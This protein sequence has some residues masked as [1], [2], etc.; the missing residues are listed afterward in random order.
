[1]L[2]RAPSFSRFWLSAYRF[3]M[4]H[5]LRAFLSTSLHIVYMLV[6]FVHRCSRSHILRAMYLISSVRC[7]LLSFIS[8]LPFVLPFQLLPLISLK[9]FASSIAPSSSTHSISLLSCSNALPSPRSCHPLLFP[10]ALTIRH[11]FLRAFIQSLTPIL[12]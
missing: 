9:P 8:I 4:E 12:S 6:L 7:S 1:M 5:P 11:L 3:A 10:S 2:T